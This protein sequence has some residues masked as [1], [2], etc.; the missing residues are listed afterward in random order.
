MTLRI[1]VLSVQ[2]EIPQ[3]LLDGLSKH[4]DIYIS[5]KM[6]CKNLRDPLIGN[7]LQYGRKTVCHY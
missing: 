7:T 4:L 6:N 3:Q 5:L 2:S 1:S